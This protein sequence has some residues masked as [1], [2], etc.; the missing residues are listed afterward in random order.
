M[1]GLLML[2][3]QC[4]SRLG[5]SAACRHGLVDALPLCHVNLP[6]LEHPT[7]RDAQAGGEPAHIGEFRC[8]AIAESSV[9]VHATGNGA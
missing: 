4:C 7:L 8:T 9:S 2:I 3:M 1:Q 5:P 6:G